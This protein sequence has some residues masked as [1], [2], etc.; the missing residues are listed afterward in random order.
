[1]SQH[2]LQLN[3]KFLFS[4]HIF[5]LHSF[6]LTCH[7]SVDYLNIFYSSRR[8]YYDKNIMTKVHGKRYAYKFDFRGLMMA[9]QAQTGLGLDN[10]AQQRSPTMPTSCHSHHPHNLY[11]GGPTMPAHQLAGHHQLNHQSHQHHLNFSGQS[12]HHPPPPP[13]HYG[14]TWPYRYST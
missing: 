11:A 8:Y 10:A 12:P 7:D 2:L 13:P 4:Y 3:Y 9:C 6:R 5:V 1:M 14:L